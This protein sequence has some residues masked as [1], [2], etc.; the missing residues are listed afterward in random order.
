MRYVDTI[1][2]LLE[3]NDLEHTLVGRP[4]NGLSIEQRKRLIIAVEL[5]AKPS[6]LIFLDE[7]TSGLDGQAAFN[8]VRFLRKLSA[9]AVRHLSGADAAKHRAEREF[10]GN[11]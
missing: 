4:G 10:H 7:P 11:R 2:D 8:T 3:L 9:A 5:V 1:V 6:I